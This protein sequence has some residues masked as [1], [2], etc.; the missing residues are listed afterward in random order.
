MMCFT[1]QHINFFS[2]YIHVLNDLMSYTSTHGSS[3]AVHTLYVNTRNSRNLEF[4]SS[5]VV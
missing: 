4:Y 2:L 1:K 5:D 3:T